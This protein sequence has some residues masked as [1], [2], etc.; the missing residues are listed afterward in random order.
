[1]V[2]KT[3]MPTG[4]CILTTL[5]TA[6]VGSGVAAPQG[7]VWSKI[8][9]ETHQGNWAH[10]GWDMDLPRSLRLLIRSFVREEEVDEG[11]RMQAIPLVQQ[12]IQN[13]KDDDVKWNAHGAEIFLT[14]AGSLAVPQ[15]ELAMM[16]GDE[17][18]R[19]VAS[20]ILLQAEGVSDRTALA[21]TCVW[22]MRDG[23]QGLH[24]LIGSRA[25]GILSSSEQLLKE[26]TP[27]LIEGLRSPDIQLRI[28]SATLLC[29]ANAEEHVD[30]I[31]E[32]LAPL[33]DN[34]DYAGTAS[35][36]LCAIAFLGLPALEPLRDRLD[37][38]DEQGSRLTR[39]LFHVIAG[40]DTHGAREMPTSERRDITIHAHDAAQSTSFIRFVGVYGKGY[41]SASGLSTLVL[42]D[43][44]RS[45]WHRKRAAT[46]K[47][48]RWAVGALL[49]ATERVARR[50]LEC[51][52]FGLSP[53]KRSDNEADIRA[54]FDKLLIE[55]G[56]A[57]PDPPAFRDFDNCCGPILKPG[58][59]DYSY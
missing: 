46:T 44:W 25:Y 40:R 28:N 7:N 11:L 41:L 16:V 37:D 13:L 18:Q 35:T 53:D 6:V 52:I 50:R 17:Q 34:D 49:G 23:G 8:A 51:L 29:L 1:L 33:L 31:V 59:A 19:M 39:H 57:H 10:L 45:I 20:Q 32:I 5:L 27:A 54:W 43:C 56:P 48:E 58:E 47:A 15:L 3:I 9:T 22:L 55:H 30:R 24:G 26:A 12:A 14:R 42:R 2:E 36:A 21:E 4:A 38:R